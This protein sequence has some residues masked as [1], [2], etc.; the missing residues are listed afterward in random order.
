MRSTKR[1]IDLNVICAF[2]ILS[3]FPLK[4]ID[5]LLEVVRTLWLL[6]RQILYE[7]NEHTETKK[8]RWKEGKSEE[9]KCCHFFH[10]K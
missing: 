8:K 6:F 9:R 4:Y 2:P 1:A 5:R 10:K 7:M 3:C